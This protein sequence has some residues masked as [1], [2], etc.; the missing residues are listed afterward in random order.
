MR[1]LADRLLLL[2]WRNGLERVTR[3][4][5]ID[6]IYSRLAYWFNHGRWP[7]TKAPDTFTDYLMRIKLSK[8]ICSAFRLQ[9]TDK[10]LAK[11]YVAEVLGPGFVIPT[12]AVLRNAR[13]IDAYA[14][15][16]DCMIKPT[17]ASGRALCR[18]AGSPAV[19]RDLLKEWLRYSHYPVRRETNYRDLKHKIIVEELFLVKETLPLDYKVHCFHGRPK[20]IHMISNGQGKNP[21]SAIYST[22]WELLPLRLKKPGGL[23]VERPENLQALIETAAR[24]SAAF[25]Y[26]RVDLYTDGERICVGELTSLPS[27]ASMRVQPPEADHLL[28]VFFTNPDADAAELFV[29]IGDARR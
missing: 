21:R 3:F 13:E 4:P 14:F 29:G 8:D 6:R 27:G 5:F 22:D 7:N 11:A 25:E 10:E 19:D 26:V 9:V 17:H 2:I 24:I 20:L 12:I 1:E 23:V 15:P 18:R 28:G 16:D